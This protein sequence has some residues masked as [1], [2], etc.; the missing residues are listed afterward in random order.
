MTRPSD[1]PPEIWNIL[2]EEIKKTFSRNSNR[3]FTDPV[4]EEI[5]NKL[6]KCTVLNHKINTYASKLR[7]LTIKYIVDV[8]QDAH[9]S[10]SL[11]LDSLVNAAESSMIN[12]DQFNLELNNILELVKSR[13]NFY[14]EALNGS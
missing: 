6:K 1:I 9:T 3:S 4:I 12:I 11:V 14:E 5:N 10:M 2:N 8:D 7:S 13:V